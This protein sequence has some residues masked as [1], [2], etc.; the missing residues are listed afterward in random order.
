V[1][2]EHQLRNGEEA[3]MTAA[4]RMLLAARGAKAELSLVKE[5]Q[6]WIEPAQSLLFTAGD[7]CANQSPGLARG[8]LTEP[9]DPYLL[10]STEHGGAWWRGPL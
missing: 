9:A 8:R 10:W 4:V 3:R 1:D 5:E 7:R 2:R 6:Q